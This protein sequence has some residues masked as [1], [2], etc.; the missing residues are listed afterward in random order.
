MGHMDEQIATTL[1]RLQEDM[2]NVL[3]RLHTLEVLTVSQVKTIN[4]NNNQTF[5]FCEIKTNVV[6]SLPLYQSPQ[7]LV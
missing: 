6:I 7:A 5:L 1:L 4:Q 3:H 2:A